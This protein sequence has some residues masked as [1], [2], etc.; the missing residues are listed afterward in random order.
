MRVSG[1]ARPLLPVAQTGAG[2]VDTEAELSSSTERRPPR[3]TRALG[4]VGARGLEGD[5]RRAALR[6]FGSVT[7]RLVLE[8]RPEAAFAMGRIGNRKAAF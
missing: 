6:E 5:L 1:H 2:D 4:G 8:P 3:M 7:V